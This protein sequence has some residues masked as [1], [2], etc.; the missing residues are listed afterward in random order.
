MEGGNGGVTHG[1]R[2]GDNNNKASPSATTGGGAWWGDDMMG[3]CGARAWCG[4]WLY[5]VVTRNVHRGTGSAVNS[6]AA[7]A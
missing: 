4:W 2:A 7:L 5:R 1:V 6:V 3:V